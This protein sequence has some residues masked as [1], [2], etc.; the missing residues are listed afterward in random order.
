ME[1]R[2]GFLTCRPAPGA[3]SPDVLDQL[4]DPDAPPLQAPGV[5]VGDYLC[6]GDDLEPGALVAV[7]PHVRR[8]AGFK[9]GKRY[10]G[11]EHARIMPR[12]QLPALV[13]FVVVTN[14]DRAF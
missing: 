6:E 13:Y 1:C 10:T 3:W 2:P 9:G 11:I 4:A 8:H 5:K 12:G 7:Q 14:A